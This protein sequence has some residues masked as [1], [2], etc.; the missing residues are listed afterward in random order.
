MW[1]KIFAKIRQ[2][3]RKTFCQNLRFSFFAKTFVVAKI[4]AKNTD[5]RF[6]RKFSFS[7]Q[8]L[9]KMFEI[10]AKNIRYYR[11]NK[12]FSRKRKIFAKTKKFA[13]NKRDF[14]E[15]IRE[16]QK[17]FAKTKI[18]A[19]IFALIFAKIFVSTLVCAQ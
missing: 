15:N 12:R 2:Y 1:A 7:Q 8:F 18:F 3:F 13:K 6:S 11:E 10:Y 16:N 17:I 4:F 5:K 9:R 14:C 19:K